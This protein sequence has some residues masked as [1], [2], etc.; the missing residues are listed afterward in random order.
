MNL[1]SVI[2]L[3]DSD[4]DNR[5]MYAAFLSS[6]GYVPVSVATA[7][8]ALP[9][10]SDADVVITE[11]RLT[12]ALN[13]LEFIAALRRDSRTRDLPIITLSASVLELDRKRAFDAG[14]NV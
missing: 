11:T 14:T 13:G 3:V 9:L 4:H 2:L 7:E 10:A 5:E 6:K 1:S 12:G 8:E